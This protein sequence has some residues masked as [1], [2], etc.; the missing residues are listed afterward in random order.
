MPLPQGI[1]DL[2]VLSQK[3]DQIPDLGDPLTCHPCSSI[4]R[5]A[6]TLFPAPCHS[7]LQLARHRSGRS[8]GFA[9]VAFHSQDE[10]RSA[11][12]QTDGALF[13]GR[14]LAVRWF[15]PSDREGMGMEANG[16]FLPE[17]F[18]QQAPLTSHPTDGGMA[19][20]TVAGRAMQRTGRHAVSDPGTP[21]DWDASAADQA[22]SVAPWVSAMSSLVASTSN[23]TGHGGWSRA[24]LQSS[25]APLLPEVRPHHLI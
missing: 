13:L 16:F 1:Y 12:L 10:A 8:A 23:V 5:N 19:T 20:N 18:A 11:L 3:V 15:L 22:P 9:I 7:P 14:L 6:D 21:P 25:A 4:Y 24:R 17:S 2:A